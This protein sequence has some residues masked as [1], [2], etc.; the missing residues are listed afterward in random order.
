[1]S[2]KRILLAFVGALAGAIVFWIALV[3]TESGFF[4]LD[5]FTASLLVIIVPIAILLLVKDE[6]RK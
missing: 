4:V 2:T 6:P 3:S 1:M 5:P